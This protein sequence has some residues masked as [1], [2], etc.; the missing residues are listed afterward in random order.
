MPAG[1][2][3]PSPAPS[4]PR[5]GRRVLVLVGLLACWFVSAGAV[6]RPLVDLPSADRPT[7]ARILVPGGE[8]PRLLGGG[9]DLLG[10]L[11]TF[12]RVARMLE[13]RSSTVHA[14]VYAPV[15][16]DQGAAEGFAWLDAVL[17]WPL[18]ITMGIPA[19]YHVHLL[20][21]LVAVQASAWLVLRAEAS[22]GERVD[23]PAVGSGAALV[24]SCLLVHVPLLERELL[25]GR[26][27]Q[28][29]LVLP[30]LFLLVVVRLERA[31]GRTEGRSVVGLAAGAGVLLG[32]SCYVY[33][34]HALA[35]A[36][37]G[38]GWL[39]L[40]RDGPWRRRGLGVGGMALVAALVAAGPAW[41]LVGPL[42]GGD[43]GTW[44]PD[45]AAPPTWAVDLGP[46]GLGIRGQPSVDLLRPAEVL[47]ALLGPGIP[48][49]LVLAAAGLC[50][51][52][53]ARACRRWTLVS[54]ALLP[55]GLGPLVGVGGTTLPAPLG[56]L[57]VVLPP[58]AR[59]HDPERL[60]VAP[61]VG[62]LAAVA[63]GCATVATRQVP[64]AG[65]GLA[66]VLAVGAGATV[67][68]PALSMPTSTFPT[69]GFWA[70]LPHR[71]PG[72]IIQV[73]LSSSN[74]D[75]AFQV[76]HRQPL[77]GGPG[78]RGVGI[79]P[80]AH[81]RYCAENGLL[82]AFEALAAGSPTVPAA[83]SS[84]LVRLRADGFRVVVVHAPRSVAPVEQYEALLGT[85]AWRRGLYAALPL[86][87][88]VL[89]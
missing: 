58:L 56:L 66:V 65:L 74:E 20:L 24:L 84:D 55:L 40:G 85:T 16:W 79:R 45:L 46:F 48:L 34:F 71:H 68:R 42:L 21:L 67:R 88:A 87:E 78:I 82:R 47:D 61:L 75:Y 62:L 60:L 15:G 50:F 18:V 3:T 12:D 69:R 22:G 80:E 2:T 31:V 38:A 11:W 37:L 73:P 43:G 39:A 81:V 17:A 41:R 25:E 36:L 13:G 77:L 10:T 44:I 64:T 4:A 86:P 72:G 89:P 26:S 49:L 59:C 7:L 28:V 32:A 83:T 19:F 76:V 30:L 52:P 35:F 53:G 9:M 14:D 51:V 57:Q 29:H 1:D 63:A 6:F 23:A 27:T 8:E 54:V 33:W 5:R 70:E